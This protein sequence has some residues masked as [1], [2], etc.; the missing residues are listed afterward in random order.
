MKF[1]TLACPILLV[2]ITFGAGFLFTGCTASSGRSLAGSTAGWFKPLQYPSGERRPYWRIGL[3]TRRIESLADMQTRNDG[4]HVYTFISQT[5][6]PLYV[7]DR[8]SP[9]YN[10]PAVA[11]LYSDFKSYA[12]LDVEN[13][14]FLENLHRQ[15]AEAFP[16]P[17]KPDQEQLLRKLFNAILDARQFLASEAI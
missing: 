13:L 15:L 6:P 5:Q 1:S 14:A 7:W 16:E 3:S 2:V 4:S 8:S 10:S 12:T 9:L 17:R 11:S